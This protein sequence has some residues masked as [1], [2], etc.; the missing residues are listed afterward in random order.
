M[1]RIRKSFKT[2]VENMV[3]CGL[4]KSYEQF[5]SENTI[6]GDSVC[7]LFDTSGSLST[8]STTVNMMKKSSKLNKNRK[9]EFCYNCS[10]CGHRGTIENDE[11]QPESLT[12]NLNDKL[13]N[14][15][16]NN[17]ERLIRAKCDISTRKRTPDE[18]LLSCVVVNNDLHGPNENKNAVSVSVSR[19]ISGV[20][21]SPLK[22]NG[23]FDA[24]IKGRFLQMFNTAS[25]ESKDDGT[26]STFC[27]NSSNQLQSQNRVTKQQRIQSSPYKIHSSTIEN[28]F[29]F[30]RKHSKKQNNIQTNVLQNNSNRHVLSLKS[31]SNTKLP[32]L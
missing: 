8:S 20:K 21:F 12:G 18:S 26:S 28:T 15:N 22:N 29:D 30:K 4:S 16:N 32:K 7:N 13:N 9:N 6:I 11:L 19:T 27:Y 23:T 24:L 25:T 17:N 10:E 14:E 31:Q 1:G 5:E 3:T 2:H